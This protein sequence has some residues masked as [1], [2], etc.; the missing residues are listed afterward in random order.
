MTCGRPSPGPQASSPCSSRLLSCA[1]D[2]P[3]GA[4]FANKE[5]QPMSL[6]HTTSSDV[7]LGTV[8]S[9]DGTLIGYRQL[10]S[11]PAVVV[12]SGA[13]ISSK[14]HLGLA[15]ALSDSFT[16]YLPDRRGRGRS[17]PYGPH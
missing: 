13:M 8:T 1:T 3:D 7:T 15:R 4:P 9:A 12:V 16:V 17:G 6:T 10:G 14:S 2:A 11:G 5:G